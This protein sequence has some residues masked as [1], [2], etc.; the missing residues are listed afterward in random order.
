[1]NS[2]KIA[3]ANRYS[4]A[5]IVLHWLVVVLVILQYAASGA[6]LRTHSVAMGGLAPSRSDLSWQ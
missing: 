5:Q 2:N 4:V 3:T 6:I 1:M